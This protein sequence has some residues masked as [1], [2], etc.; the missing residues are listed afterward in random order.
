VKTLIR[1]IEALVKDSGV[2]GPRIDAV[3]NAPPIT[4]RERNFSR[5][6]PAEFL[7]TVSVASSFPQSVDD[8]SYTLPPSRILNIART[9]GST[10]TFRSA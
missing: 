4:L 8:L 9:D 6:S 10:Y 5:S 1:C 2:D 7:W 3:E